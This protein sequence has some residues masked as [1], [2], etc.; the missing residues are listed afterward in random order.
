MVLL[1]ESSTKATTLS[2]TPKQ[3][4]MSNIKGDEATHNLNLTF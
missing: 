2:Y 3:K 1:G 4:K